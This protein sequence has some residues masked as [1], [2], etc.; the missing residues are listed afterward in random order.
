[1]DVFM[2]ASAIKSRL[3]WSPKQP[4]KT[5]APLSRRLSQSPSTGGLA[6]FAGRQSNPGLCGLALQLMVNALKMPMMAQI[7]W[8][9]CILW[10]N[11]Q[12]EGVL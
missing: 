2:L 1:M 3:P 6:G 4:R 10:Y 12:N 8:R 11:K 7:R 5:R 9:K